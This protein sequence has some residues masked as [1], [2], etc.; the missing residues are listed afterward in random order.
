MFEL[1]PLR[2]RKKLLSKEKMYEREHEKKYEPLR[3]G[4]GPNLSG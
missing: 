3:L 4:K 1:E 2:K